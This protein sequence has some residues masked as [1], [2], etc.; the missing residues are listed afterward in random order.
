MSVHKLMM[1]E[2]LHRVYSTFFY[3]NFGLVTNEY[4]VLSLC[5]SVLEK[6]HICRILGVL[7]CRATLE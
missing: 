3:K 1:V 6:K 5:P 2:S 7:L 4:A